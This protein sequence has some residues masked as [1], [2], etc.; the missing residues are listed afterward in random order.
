MIP[1]GS[2]RFPVLISPNL[3][4]WALALLRRGY[5]SAGYA[6]AMTAWTTRL[7]WPPCIPITIS[8]VVAFA[9]A[10][11]AGLVLD[12]IETVPQVDTKHIGMF[13]Y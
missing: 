7:R 3:Q 2:G 4:G 11:A 1:L 10:W 8:S 13:G 6:R 9:G 12:Y 5:I